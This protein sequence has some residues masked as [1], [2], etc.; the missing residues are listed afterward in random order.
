M[1]LNLIETL[2][3]T[4][5]YTPKHTKNTKRTF[6]FSTFA[7]IHIFQKIKFK[8]NQRFMMIFMAFFKLLRATQP[9]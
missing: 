6:H 8:L 5:I 3:K 9:N 7:N 4:S 1:T 2:N